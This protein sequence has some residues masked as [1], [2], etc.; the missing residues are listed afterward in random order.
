MTRAE[1][2]PSARARIAVQDFKHIA[3]LLARAA[4]LLL[5]PLRRRLTGRA[6]SYAEIG[7]RLR[8]LLDESGVATR[9]LGQFLALRLD[10]LPREICEELDK[11]FDSAKPMERATVRDIIRSELGRSC[12]DVFRSFDPAPIAV[13]SIAQVHRAVTHDGQ[14][15]AV[16]IQRA[17]IHQAF[18]SEI[19]NLR[20]IARLSDLL[21]LTGTISALETMEEFAEFTEAEL[22]FDREGATADR[23]RK[24]ARPGC[25]VPEI[26]WDLS[27]PRVLVM[28][29]I[30]GITI[31][32]ICRMF[33]SARDA[34]VARALPGVDLL[35]LLRRI[36]DE[37]FHQLFDI[38]FF[39]GDPNPGNILVQ[40]D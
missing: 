9:K 12:E 24:S 39:H 26:R 37:C 6:V 1:E 13:A 17:G 30:E 18:R 29:F 32:A 28:E 40:K 23:L 14:V 11:L 16:K 31:L 33:E 35:D 25:H 22:H 2:A 8:L 21:R 10:L 38:G 19:R 3:V 27:T 5:M 15:V 20:R 4:G 7:I 34:D 36:A